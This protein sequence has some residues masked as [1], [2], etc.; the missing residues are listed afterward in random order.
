M[1][2]KSKHISSLEARIRDIV[3]QH[4]PKGWLVI[5]RPVRHGNDG[6][7]LATSRTIYV[8]YLRDLH[9][10]YVFLH[11]CGH[12]HMKHV[13]A[14]DDKTKDMPL[15]QQEWEAEQYAIRAMR[16][17]GFRVPNYMMKSA[18]AYV[19]EHLTLEDYDEDAYPA[20]VKFAFT[21]TAERR[22]WL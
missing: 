4:K 11:E 1:S 17:A 13:R 19:G 22:K 14:D 10:L 7:A 20:A 21:R 16:A 9:A 18:R 5:E 12:V 2:R 8:P 6:L 15:W 3:R